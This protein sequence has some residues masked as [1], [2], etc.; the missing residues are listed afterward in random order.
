ML[1]SFFCKKIVLFFNQF[2]TEELV[3]RHPLK[4]THVFLLLVAVVFLFVWY[5]FEFMA[6]NILDEF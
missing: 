2:Q 4:V 3:P 6:F 1:D 5:H